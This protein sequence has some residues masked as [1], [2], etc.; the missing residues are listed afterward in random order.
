MCTLYLQDDPETL[1][2]VLPKQLHRTPEKPPLIDCAC[3][4]QLKTIAEGEEDSLESTPVASPTGSPKLVR[5]RPCE[6][7]R[8]L[9]EE[10]D[11]CQR[12]FV[13]R[14]QLLRTGLKAIRP[15]A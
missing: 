10:F 5:R 2:F 14:H 12:A 6:T 15:G 1:A 7:C 13:P 4:G 8:G 3:G 9:N 11:D